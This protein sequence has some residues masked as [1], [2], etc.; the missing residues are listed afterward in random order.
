MTA[1]IKAQVNH[2]AYLIEKM[3]LL[4]A[5]SGKH[6]E[7]SSKDLDS[8]IDTTN[9]MAALSQEIEMTL[10]DFKNDFAMV[11]EETGTI[12]DISSQTNLLALN[13]SIEAARAGEAG[14]GFAVVAEQIRTLST[15]TKASSSK[16][17]QSLMHLEETSTKMMHTME[18][19]LSL[20]RMTLDK[21]T[22]AGASISKISE[23]TAQLEENIQII[24]TAMKDVEQS[25]IQLVDNMDQVSS[26]MTKMSK[27][28]SDSNEISHRMLS[29][30][31]ESANNINSIETVVESLMC[32]LGIGG[33]MG[34]E[35]LQPGMKFTVTLEDSSNY[36]GDIVERTE[37]TLTVSLD[38]FPPI[39]KTTECEL[40]V[41]V[42]NVLYHW[43]RAL[44]TK[45]SQIIIESRPKINNRRKY[46]RAD[47]SNTCSITIANTSAD[48]IA[49]LPIDATMD[50]ISANGFAFL[51]KD[52][53]FTD[54]KGQTSMLRSMILICQIIMN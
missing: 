19:T 48:G 17:S 9:N 3:V 4:T 23:D 2:V 52:P 54:H 44:I 37:N 30:Y 29:K 45:D 21:V 46:P 13:A 40:Q 42:G 27:H 10:Q 38:N 15:G 34:V 12:E 24:D 43:K 31:D 36:H 25:N 47:L 7:V 49:P 26:I 32:E 51:T 6:T 14:K 8:L 20:I 1:K 22:T 5:T 18:E 16:I 33:F 11:K 39:T 53:F 50:N 41:T 35:D 28:I